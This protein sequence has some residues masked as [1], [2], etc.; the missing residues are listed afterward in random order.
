MIDISIKL[1]GKKIDGR[2]GIHVYFLLLALNNLKKGGKLAFIMPADTCEGIFA[3]DIW[4]YITSPYCLEAVVTFSPEATP[5]PNIDTNAVIFFITNR[6][7]KQHIYKIH[8][9]TPSEQSLFDVVKSNFVESSE[10]VKVTEVDLNKALK[11]GL[12]RDTNSFVE[13]AFVLK[14]FAKIMRG[15]ATGENSFFFMNSKTKLGLNLEDKYFIR[16]IG[17]TRDLTEDCIT[18]DLL[19]KL[20][21]QGRPTYLLS[22]DN[23]PFKNLSQNIQKYIKLGETK[24]INKKASLSRVLWK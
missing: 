3:K 16:A 4:S 13:H 2:A 8:C 23:I 22:L 6:P 17:R 5:F 18:D 10:N 1:L 24:G 7:K 15:I 11:V 14:D 12:S 19:A 9:N 20:D 21:K